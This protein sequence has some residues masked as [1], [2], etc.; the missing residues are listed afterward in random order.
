MCLILFAYRQ[1]PR[2]RLIVAANRDEYYD[3]PTQPALFWQDVPW[4]LAGRDLRNHG[5]WMGVTRQGRFAAITNYRAP[6]LQK[7]HAPSRGLLVRAFLESAE[8]PADYLH[9]LHAAAGRYNGFNLLVGSAA[10]D[11]HY[12]S[13]RGDGPA[14]L[15]PGIY[16]L[17]NHLLNTPWPKV[18]KGRTALAELIAGSRDPQPEELLQLLADRSRPPDASLPDTG[19]GRVKERMLAPLFIVGEDYGTRSS[20]VVLFGT[21]GGVQFIERTFV[22][23]NSVPPN[24]RFAT[25]ATRTYRFEIGSYADDSAV[26]PVSKAAAGSGSV[27]QTDQ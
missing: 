3:R 1:H 20:S 2:Y 17:S 19:V 26:R 7:P 12:F 23:G 15:K 18:I 5:T 4:L 9:R 25:G 13:N 24:S 27:K 6:A 22:P 21:D 8:P 14:S 11:L 10:G 16:G